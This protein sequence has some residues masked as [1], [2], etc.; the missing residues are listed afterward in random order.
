[1]ELFQ[2]ID[3]Q[4]LAALKDG[5]E[6]AFRTVYISYTNY[7][8]RYVFKIVKS[9]A[10][11]EEIV[12]TVMMKVWLHRAVIDPGKSFDGWLRTITKN[13]AFD[14][15]KEAG[16]NQALQARIREDIQQLSL[17]PADAQLELKEFRELYE[18][19]IRLLPPQQ[20]KVFHLSRDLEMSHAE[21][22]HQLSI[23]SNTVRNH[24]VAALGYIRRYFKANMGLC[25]TF[26]II[27]FDRH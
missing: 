13:A 8:R 27:F 16:R 9:E 25:I 2:Q 14:Y 20:Q 15:L 10:V 3:K 17:Q 19:A 11:A 4:V 12:Q 23:S 5:D 6:G 24:M 26:L 18:A 22:A 7:L 21:I 1:M